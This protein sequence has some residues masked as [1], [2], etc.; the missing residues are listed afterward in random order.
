MDLWQIPLTWCSKKSK[1]QLLRPKS[2]QRRDSVTAAEHL[3]TC[4]WH[5]GTWQCWLRVRLDDPKG[6]FQPEQF[7]TSMKTCHSL[8]T[9]KESVILLCTSLKN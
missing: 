4:T 8:T 9:G 3:S 1:A 7:Y 6:T 5:L 2:L